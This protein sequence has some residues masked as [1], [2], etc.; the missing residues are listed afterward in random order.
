[1]AEATAAGGAPGAG[2]GADGGGGTAVYIDQ[3]NSKGLVTSGFITG[4]AG[5]AFPDIQGEEFINR[6]PIVVGERANVSEEGLAGA[7]LD[8]NGNGDTTDDSTIIGSMDISDPDGNPFTVTMGI[9]GVTLTSGGETI[10]WEL[11]DDGHTLI[12]KIVRVIDGGEG[13]PTTEEEHIIEVFMNDTGNYEIR[14]LGPIDHP[15]GTE[16]DDLDFDIPVTATD[17]FGLSGTGFLNVNVE[18]DS[19]TLAVCHDN[20]GG[21]E[22]SIES[23]VALSTQAGQGGNSLV[24]GLGGPAGFGENTMFRNDD[25]STGFI[26][27]TSIF[28]T[29]MNFYGATPY[30]GFYINNNGNITFNSPLGTFTPFAIVGNSGN[31]MIAPFFAD[32]DTRPT[33]SH[34]SPG[35]TSTGTNA[36]YWDLD[37]DNGII[38]ITWN[39][40]GY[41]S[42]ET[43]LVNAF[44]LRIFN[45]GG[46]NFGFEFRYE[47]VEWTTG[48]ASGGSGGLG[49][50]VARAGW[51]SGDGVNFFE[52]PQS[53]NQ[54]AILNLETTSNANTPQDGNWVFNVVGGQ[55]VDHDC[56]ESVTATVRE[57]GMRLTTGDLSDG[58]QTIV[59]TGADEAISAT[60]SL[61][62]LYSF[63]ADGPGNFVMLTDTSGLPELYSQGEPVEYDVEGNVLTATA[64]G[65]DV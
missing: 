14:L 10:V 1:M 31:P 39:D 54:S 55:V 8:E 38:T 49:G 22:G 40:V 57:D 13:G 36:V 2:G 20:E 19:P 44:Q 41:F 29:G 4:P 6:P 25:G 34:V 16:E 65:R 33:S 28:P 56:V 18:D 17:V 5:I 26:N 15:D 51:T 12:G 11:Q 46:G 3:A 58:N 7:N 62:V 63:G 42:N 32:V 48:G 50:T 37:T 53:G 52:L 9:P 61:R 45:T 30:T 23:L 35:G 43:D 24:D 60:G 64:D 59:N 47:N 21:G 27:V